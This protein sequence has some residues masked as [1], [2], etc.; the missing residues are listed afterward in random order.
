[1]VG[2]VTTKKQFSYIFMSKESGS[3]VDE[4]PSYIF[5][6]LA[7]DVTMFSDE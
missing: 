6:L 5:H 1:M 3:W 2:L 7:N 4:S